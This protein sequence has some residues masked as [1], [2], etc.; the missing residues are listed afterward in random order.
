MSD[1]KKK[2]KPH[3]EKTKPVSIRNKKRPLVPADKI[4]HRMK[5]DA[6][7]DI[8]QLII[9]YVDRFLGIQEIDMEYIFQKIVV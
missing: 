7:F 8:N 3:Q 6:T 4:L 1:I 5:W 2:K 9:G